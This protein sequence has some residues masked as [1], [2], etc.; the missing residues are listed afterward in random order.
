METLKGDSSYEI[1]A[2]FVC[3]YDTCVC[4]YEYHESI[5]LIKHD[6]CKTI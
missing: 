2:T 5:W 4:M 1:N 3:M 6:S